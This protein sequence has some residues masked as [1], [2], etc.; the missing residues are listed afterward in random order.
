MAYNRKEKIG[1]FILKILRDFV[2]DLIARIQYRIAEKIDHNSS[3]L[4]PKNY[5]SKILL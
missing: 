2:Y 1:K 4:L 3:P 5:Q